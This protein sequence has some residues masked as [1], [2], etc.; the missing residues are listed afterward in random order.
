MRNTDLPSIRLWHWAHIGTWAIASMLA[1]LTSS[2]AAE[3]SA[4]CTLLQPAELESALGGK[5][6]RFSGHHLESADVCSGQVGTRKVVIRTAK[7]QRQDGGAV[8]RKGIETARR[9]GAQV[10]IK[11]EGD[12][13]CSTL[14]PPASLPQMG[15]NTTCSVFRAGKVLA[16]EVTAPSRQDMVPMEA[17]RSLV[18][19]AATRL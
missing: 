14:I 13:T 7:R 9:M 16:V 17:V 12:L 11:T 2:Y 18:Q 8:E 10:E 3:P 5:A 19:K 6:A 15:F 4:A 1:T